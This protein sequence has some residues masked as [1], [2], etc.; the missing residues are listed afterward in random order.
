VIPALLMLATFFGLWELYTQLSGIDPLLL[1]PA[2]AVLSALWEERGLLADNLQTT[3]VEVVLG[4]LL[5]LI[6]GAVMA[7][8]LH[9]SPRTRRASYPLLIAT[10]AIPIVAIAPL[11]MTWFGFGLLPKVLIVALVCFFPIVVT[12]LDGLRRV[13]DQQRTMLRSLGASRWQMLRFLEVPAALP[14][15]LSGAKVAVAV[16]SIAAVFAEYAGSDRGLGHLLL[17]SIPGLQTDL[18]WATVLV[19]AALSITCFA[20]IAALERRLTPW[21]DP[22]K[23]PTP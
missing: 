15:A 12:T 8:A 3:A 2:S 21:A 17:T 22:R 9:L 7:T 1:P 16:G 18:A 20:A 5:A 11:L 13:D 10:Q 6:A 4:L 23:D 14:A 19:L